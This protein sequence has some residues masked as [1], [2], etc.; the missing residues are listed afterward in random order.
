M[1][2]RGCLGTARSHCFDDLMAE[3]SLGK[4]WLAVNGSFLESSYRFFTMVAAANQKNVC[5][6]QASFHIYSS[7]NKVIHGF[8]ADNWKYW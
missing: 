6:C 1:T 7:F 3:S 2:R 5:F 8:G 4:A